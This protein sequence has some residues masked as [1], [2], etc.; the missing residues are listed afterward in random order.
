MNAIKNFAEFSV[1]DHEVF[2]NDKNGGNT[3]CG[4][5]VHEPCFCYET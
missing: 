2:P 3:N 4:R 1:C 5:T